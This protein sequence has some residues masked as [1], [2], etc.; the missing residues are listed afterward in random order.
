[1]DVFLLDVMT[2]MLQSPLYF[3]SYI[4]RRTS[5]GDKFYATH[6]LTTFSYHLR[7][8]LWLDEENS[9][10]YLGDDIG[11]DLDLAMLT[12]RDGAPGLATP[13]GILT[14]YKGTKFDELIQEIDNLEHPSIV[15]L[16]FL[17]LSLS[18]D[19]IENI[20]KSLAHILKLTKED[21][22][23]HD[24]TFLFGELSS[25]L[26]IHC[27]ND[28]PSISMPRLEI[29]CQRR[30]YKHKVRS[31]I[32]ICIEPII[33]KIKFGINLKHEWAQSDEMD[34]KVKILHSFKGKDNFPFTTSKQ[35]KIGRNETCPCKSGKKY[36]NCCLS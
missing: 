20:N 6:E 18:G 21:G 24:V 2:E 31:W 29:H 1:M 16:G 8:N 35:K 33:E 4:N 13:K 17:L 23:N 19:T 10:M 36:K 30:K 25:G 12:R 7:K 22:L 26:T 3:L 34:E 11:A 15:D 28:H 9:M 5:Y 27:N 14:D 32:G